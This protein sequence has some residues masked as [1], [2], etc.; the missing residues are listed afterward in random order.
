MTPKDRVIIVAVI[1]MFGVCLFLSLWAIFQDPLVVRTQAVELV[2]A[3]GQR[4]AVL[5]ISPEGTVSLG[6]FDENGKVR[7]SVGIL[8]DGRPISVMKDASGNI[9]WG[10]P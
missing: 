4:R 2:D 8:P 5:G 10:A 1:C 9:V 6:L 7:S 3:N